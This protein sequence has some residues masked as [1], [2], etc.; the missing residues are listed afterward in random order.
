MFLSVGEIMFYRKTLDIS[1]V[2]LDVSGLTYLRVNRRV[3][4][5]R[6]DRLR[7]QSS[8]Y[9]GT[10]ARVAWHELL[11]HRHAHRPS[12]QV[13]S[14]HLVAELNQNLNIIFLCS[15]FLLSKKKGVL[16]IPLYSVVC[17]LV[18]STLA[19]PFKRLRCFCILEEW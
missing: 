19:T 1:D 13:S 6:P 12:D 7:E 17:L 8:V 5:S 15:I 18:F 4:V 14:G 11:H 3:F 10:A 9:A 2:I 16:C